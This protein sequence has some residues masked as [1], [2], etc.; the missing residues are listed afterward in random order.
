MTDHDKPVTHKNRFETFM[1]LLE[2]KK[3]V[4]LFTLFLLILVLSDLAYF[5]I[6]FAIVLLVY[7]ALFKKNAWVRAFDG[8]A[9]LLLC[10]SLSQFAFLILGENQGLQIL[11][12][13]TF[14]PTLGYL[15]GKILV[16]NK[17]NQKNIFFLVLFLVIAFSFVGWASVVLNLIEKGFAQSNRSIQKISTGNTVLAT[18]MAQYFIFN[19][20]LLGLFL[21]NRKRLNLLVNVILLF[22]YITSLLCVFRLGSRTCIVITA[23]TTI[24]SMF[25]AFANQNYKENLKLVIAIAVVVSAVVFLV[26][27]DLDS[28]YLSVLGERLQDPNASESSSAGGRTELWSNSI[29]KL[30]THP[31]GWESRQYAHNMWLDLARSVGI[32]PL[33]F[34]M[35]FNAKN[36]INLVKLVKRSPKNIL[37]NSSLITLSIA[38]ILYFFVEPVLE[39]SIFLFTFYCILQGI[40]KKN[41]QIHKST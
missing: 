34:L 12:I 33:V 32:I 20:T 8:D 29:G 24:L 14:L 4:G 26:P 9:L 39:A 7:I 21:V 2:Y 23:L 17:M 36:F 19:M 11:T 22:F 37:V 16:P 31:L 41:I 28:A 3:E 6:Y 1:T 27:F 40:V 13:S 18:G 5:G 30:F 15:T 25:Y 38:A 35:I 10:F